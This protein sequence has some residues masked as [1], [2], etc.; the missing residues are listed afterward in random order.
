MKANYIRISTVE[1]NTARQEKGKN[2]FIDKC[3]GSIA[4]T[5]RTQGGKLIALARDGKLIEVAVNSID[6]LGR[7]L[8]D[9]KTTIDFFTSCG[10]NVI[11]TKEGLRTLDDDGKENPTAKLIIG[12]LG[13]LAEFEL[14][15]IKERQMEGI[16]KAK[17]RGTYKGRNKGSIESEAVFLSKARTQRIIKYLKEDNSFRRTALLS[18]SSLSLVQKVNRLLI[19]KLKEIE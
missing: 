11:S 9:I 7:N 12:I 19:K 1:Q 16:A 15:R 8:I 3:S 6:R 13:T 5:E 10:V 18:K 2:D 14:S 17:L 4:F